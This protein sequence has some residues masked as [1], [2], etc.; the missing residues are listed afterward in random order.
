MGTLVDIVGNEEAG[1]DCIISHKAADPVVYQLAR[2][3]G[4]GRLV[5]ATEDEV[6]AVEDLLEDDKSN[7]RALDTGQILECSTNGSEG[8][9][10]LEVPEIG[11][12][13][14]N[15]PP[16][17]MMDSEGVD[18]QPKERI[19]SLVRHASDGS[20][21]QSGSP[22]ECSKTFSE[23]DRSKT[24]SAFDTGLKPD[25]SLLNGEIHLDNLSVKDL[26]ETFKA[27]FGRETS[28]KD[29][30]W[31]KRRII[32]GLTNS[33]DF[34]TTSFVIIDNRVVRKQ[35][36]ETCES[37]DCS[38]LYDCVVT[39][40]IE[41]HESPSTSHDKQSE[42]HLIANETNMESSTFQDKCGSKDTETEERPAKRIR[43]P[44]KRYI[45]ELSEGESRDSG[46]KIVS[47]AKH[48]AYDQP[49]AKVWARPVQNFGLDRRYLTRKDSLGGSGI[50]IPYVSRIRR[51]RPR[52]NLMNLMKL[53]PTRE[54]ISTS[55]EKNDVA[56]STQLDNERGVNAP[57]NSLSPRWIEE[58][59][60]VASERSTPYT[61]STTIQ[62][63]EEVKLKNVESYRNN[64]DEEVVTVPTANGGM[65]RKH[66]RPWT[67]SEVVNWL[68][69]L[70]N[71]VLVDGLRSNALPLHHILTELQLTLR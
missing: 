60:V 65:R 53:Q 39:S 14:P 33:C 11:T 1:V 2:V 43:K 64:S 19:P 27:T 7:V 44:T 55:L 6:M 15:I 58:P 47:S 16:H 62:L 38:V 49:S 56:S 5:P 17:P 41:N 34:S 35:K 69:G 29:K 18:V 48:P 32:M 45:E 24:N 26:Q 57:N 40:A 50:Q 22:G 46:A 52:E 61:E 3:D 25:F 54:G 68:M 23:L 70:L 9:P 20:V 28:V 59:P 8:Q 12:E 31:L 51:S 10:Q 67:L 30:Q 37:V 21:C 71:M 63:E 36:A 4:D 13:K 66:H 42:I